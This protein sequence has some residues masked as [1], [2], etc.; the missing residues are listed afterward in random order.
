MRQVISEWKETKRGCPQ[1]SFLCPTLWNIYQNDL[2]YVERKSR[3][4][5]YADNH[6]LY[7]A[8]KKPERA[9]D[10]ITRDGKQTFCCVLLQTPGHLLKDIILVDDDSKNPDDGKLLE[11]LPKVKT[12]R[13]NGRE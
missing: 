5:A 9:V 7:Y 4:S 3:L 13:N 11:K 10:T 12:I 1:G 6:Q 2:F 8:H